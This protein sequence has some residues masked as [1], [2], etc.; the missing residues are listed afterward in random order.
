[1]SLWWGNED[2]PDQ[3]DA[4]NAVVFR[5]GMGELGVV[6]ETDSTYV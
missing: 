2:G 6:F 1:M 3:A 4:G 5:D